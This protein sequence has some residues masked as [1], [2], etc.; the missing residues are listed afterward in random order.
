[1]NEVL[2]KYLFLTTKITLCGIFSDND[3]KMSVLD[4]TKKMT[5]FLLLED[6]VLPTMAPN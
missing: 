4:K 3:L 1:M 5:L 2:S 6:L